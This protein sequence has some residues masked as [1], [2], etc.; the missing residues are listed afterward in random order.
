MV[1]LNKNKVPEDVLLGLYE[2]LSKIISELNRSQVENFLFDLLGEEERVMLAKRLAIVIMILEE[3]SMYRISTTLKV[4]QSTVDKIKT[5]MSSG[6]F[7]DLVPLVKKN[8]KGYL[9]IL[10]ILDQI[11]TVGGIMPHY[12]QANISHR[13]RK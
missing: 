1:H 5:A 11:L 10:D 6:A 8:K 12:G 13:K 9:A 4:S 3:Y 7:V 2:Q